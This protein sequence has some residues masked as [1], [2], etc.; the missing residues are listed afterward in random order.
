MGNE[1][2][3]FAGTY[4]IN[5]PSGGNQTVG[6][7]SGTVNS[8]TGGADG[9][10]GLGGA[11]ARAGGYTCGTGGGGGF[12]G[13]GNGMFIG[14]GGGSG[15]IANPLFLRKHMYCYDCLESTVDNF[16][17]ISTTCVDDTPRAN[18]A[19]KGNGYA[20]ITLVKSLENYDNETTYTIAYNLNGGTATGSNPSSSPGAGSIR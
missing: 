20:K 12:W 2:K 18:C 9:S 8:E 17:T 14:A 7:Y 16:E 19:K 4:N 13:G 10:F 6:G 1:P 5:L 11:T 15:Y 3:S